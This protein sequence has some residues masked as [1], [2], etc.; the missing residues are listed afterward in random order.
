METAVPDT[1]HRPMV[2]RKAMS[3]WRLTA[4]GL[5]WLM[6]TQIDHLTKA[7]VRSRNGV[8]AYSAL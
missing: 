7:S 5:K 6:N 8:L 3:T 4:F 2:E 1:N